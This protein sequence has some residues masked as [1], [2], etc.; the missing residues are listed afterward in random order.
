MTKTLDEYRFSKYTNLMDLVNGVHIVITFSPKIFSYG[1]AYEVLPEI[2]RELYLST[3]TDKP[4]VPIWTIAPT[5]GQ[6]Q[7][8]M[9]QNHLLVVASIAPNENP[10]K[11]HA[12]LWVYGLHNINL[13]SSKWRK[14]FDRNM[15]KKKYIASKGSPIFIEPVTD[16]I[17]QMIRD[18]DSDLYDYYEP[19]VQYIKN[20][21]S[22][23]MGYFRQ[24]NNPNLLFHYS[25]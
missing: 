14:A 9:M 19:V 6:V 4:I 25:K 8:T 2:I 10:E 7:L 24:K 22:N 16:N 11:V 20:K 23:L 17:D 12:H 5:A 1:D 18:R 21:S 15:R 13:D 3:S